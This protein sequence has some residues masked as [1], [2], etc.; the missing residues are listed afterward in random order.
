[1]S[2]GSITIVRN[3]N[4]NT[5]SFL[6]VWYESKDKDYTQDAAIKSL[7]AAFEKCGLEVEVNEYTRQ[8]GYRATYITIK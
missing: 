2:K 5:S 6:P 7:V 3:Y 1:M 8:D 4:G